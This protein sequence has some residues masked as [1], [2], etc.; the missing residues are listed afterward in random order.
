MTRRSRIA[1]KKRNN[2][3]HQA[4]EMSLQPGDQVWV[5]DSASEAHVKPEVALRSFELLTDGGI[6][7]RRVDQVTHS[8]LPP[9]FHIYVV[10]MPARSLQLK[11]K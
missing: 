7:V 8:L 1:R 10:L 4:R 9:P 11:M 2:K 3:Q 5:S 6:A